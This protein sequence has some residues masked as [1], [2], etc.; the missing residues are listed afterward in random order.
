VEA[1]SNLTTLCANCHKIVHWLSVWRVSDETNPPLPLD[2]ALARVAHRN[3]LSQPT[4]DAMVDATNLVLSHIPDDIRADCAFRLAPGDHFFSINLENLLLY[5]TPGYP[6]GGKRPDNEMLL[7]WPEDIA[8]SVI[9]DWEAY[10]DDVGFSKGGRFGAIRCVNVDLAFYEAL[11]LNAQDWV[12]FVQA[13][14]AAGGLSRA[15]P[16]ISNVLVGHVEPVNRQFQS[17]PIPAKDGSPSDR[18]VRIVGRFGERKSSADHERAL[19]RR[20]ISSNSTRSPCGAPRKA[21]P[22]LRLPFGHVADC[23][24]G[25]RAA[26]AT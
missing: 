9:P 21:R 10:K 26:T 25:D 4:E 15:R 18:E 8:I 11:A 5:R 24:T 22:V 7:I 12:G 19:R 20:K 1:E 23:V 3:K 2:E 17:D 13:C 16:G 6:D 14:R